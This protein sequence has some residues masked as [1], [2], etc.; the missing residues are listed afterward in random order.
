MA[1]KTLILDIDGVLVRDKALLGHVR[2]NC[3]AY[4]QSKLPESKTAKETNRLLYLSHGHTARGLQQVFGIDTSDFNK[5]VYDRK[6]MDHLWSVLSSTE[7]QEDAK[8]I[9]DLTN[10]GWNVTLFT[11]APQIWADATAMAIGDNISYKCPGPDV[12]KSPL[13]PEAEAYKQFGTH[14][15]NVY[16]DDSLKNL[17]TARWLPNWKSVYYNDGPKDHHLWCPTVSS[18]WETMLFVNTIDHEINNYHSA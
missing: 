7:F 11:N 10:R 2:D 16:V 6:L 18:I 17:G 9:H 14:H 4:V 3:V 15:L 13:K 1:F 12:T 5:K 8:E